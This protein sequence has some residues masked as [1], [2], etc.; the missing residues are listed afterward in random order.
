MRVW[1]CLHGGGTE[2][3]G[4][5]RTRA[6]PPFWRQVSVG[7]HAVEPH[8]NGMFYRVGLAIFWRMHGEKFSSPE[9]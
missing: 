7:R 3:C 8:L 1:N 2:I 5:P 4:I 9:L 6:Y